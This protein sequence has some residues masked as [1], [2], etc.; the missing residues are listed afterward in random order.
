MVANTKI[1]V[2]VASLSLLLFP[3]LL[4]AVQEE[5]DIQ[6]NPDY[7]CPKVVFVG[8]AAEIFRLK[9]CSYIS[10]VTIKITY[11][12]KYSYPARLKF[13][14]FDSHGNVM[15]MD[16]KKHVFG[17]KYLEKGQYGIF[18]IQALGNEDPS[19]IEIEGVWTKNKK[20]GK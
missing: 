3:L 10:G 12:G 5:G 4:L 13:T 17:P 11:N 7:W 18:T 1:G 9:E 6:N 20:S 19:R 16:Q 2:V 8:K 14:L 15:E